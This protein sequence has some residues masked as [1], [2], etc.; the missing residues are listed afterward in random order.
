MTN[1][2]STTT[3]QEQ[4]AKPV[5]ESTATTE[6]TPLPSKDTGKRSEQSPKTPKP[7]SKE[8]GDSGKSNKSVWPST[9]LASKTP[10]K[11]KASTAKSQI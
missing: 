1:E 5:A 3:T 11:S 9:C 6:Q 7:K 10:N 8:L 2:T 4:P